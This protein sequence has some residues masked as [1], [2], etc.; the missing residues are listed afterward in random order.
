MLRAINQRFQTAP[1]EVEWPADGS[2]AASGVLV[3]TFDG[4]EQQPDRLWAPT[5]NGPGATEQS[6]SLVFAQQFIAPGVAV[7]LFGGAGGGG[8]VFR[9]GAATKINCGKAKDSAGTCSV[10]HPPG[11]PDAWC[12]S[13]ENVPP[14]TAV[15]WG[16]P[17]DTC[18]YAWGPR[19]FGGY[20]QRLTIW[21]HAHSR[22]DYNEI[23]VDAPHWRLHLADAIE[24]VIGRRDIYDAYV[25]ALGKGA[26][27]VAF[28]SRVDVQDWAAPFKP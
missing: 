4:H 26:D 22:L 23:I 28:V 7:P 5:T 14:P 3:H 24:A 25:R 6:A 20:L 13:L 8:L 9:P 21:Q 12:P 1:W 15:T 2:L 11:R 27:E 16:E 17:G 18:G 19:D 10:W